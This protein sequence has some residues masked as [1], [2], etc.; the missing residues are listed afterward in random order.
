M[1]DNATITCAWTQQS[2][3]GTLTFGSPSSCS[4]TTIGS[5]TTGTY[6][7]RLTI[8]D[9]TE[10]HVDVKY[11]GVQVDS[12]GY[13]VVPS[14]MQAIVGKLIPWGMSPWPWFDLTERGDAMS[15]YQPNPPT[16]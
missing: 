15:I 8:N 5:T 11:G 13:V 1:V 3:P 10:G 16:G 14:N 7:V 4:S 12:S 9:G 6:T 2:G